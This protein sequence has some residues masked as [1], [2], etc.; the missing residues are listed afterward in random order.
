METTRVKWDESILY[1]SFARFNEAKPKLSNTIIVDEDIPELSN[2]EI[3]EEYE[4]FPEQETELKIK[5]EKAVEGS[6][7]WEDFAND[8][9]WAM[10]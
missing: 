6:D 7:E 10:I 1:K 2:P 9:D 8:I 5:V 3:T 4:I